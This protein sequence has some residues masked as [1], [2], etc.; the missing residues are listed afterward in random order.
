MQSYF[1]R[2]FFRKKS[3][4]KKYMPAFVNICTV[5]TE[6]RKEKV[7]RVSMYDKMK[8]GRKQR[9]LSLIYLLSVGIS[10]WV[11]CRVHYA[12]ISDCFFYLNVH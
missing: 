7:Y 6:A 10:I 3:R 12:S 8:R 11:A 1:L 2:S 9:K 4:K 5:E